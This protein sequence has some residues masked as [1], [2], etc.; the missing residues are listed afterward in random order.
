MTHTLFEHL[1]WTGCNIG[2]CQRC[3]DNMPWMADGSGKHQRWY[4]M[5][6]VNLHNLA[7]QA[8]AVDADIIDA[9]YE[10]ADNERTGTRSQE[11][12][13]CTLRWCSAL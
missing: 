5:L 12:L 3:L 11:R 2:A 6:S 10:R 1:E 9:S 4:F 13:N 7:D 8:H